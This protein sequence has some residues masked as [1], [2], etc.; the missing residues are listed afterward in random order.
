MNSSTQATFPCASKIQKPY[1]KCKRWDTRGVFMAAKELQIAD[2]SNGDDTSVR[3]KKKKRSETE[4]VV[5]G[6]KE[7]RASERW[8]LGH[9]DIIHWEKKKNEP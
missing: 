3:K 6:E 4:K 2:F 5:D 1:Q 8:I 9:A 7:V